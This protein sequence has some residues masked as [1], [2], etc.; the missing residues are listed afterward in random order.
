MRRMV[1]TDRVVSVRMKDEH[2]EDLHALAWVKETTI[3]KVIRNATEAYVDQHRSDPSFVRKVADAR[4]RQ[5]RLL[6]GLMNGHST[7]HS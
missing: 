6:E 5:E 7:R 2:L 1:V 3:G 4:D